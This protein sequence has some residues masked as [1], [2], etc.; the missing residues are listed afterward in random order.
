MKLCY[1][2]HYC[3]VLTHSRLPVAPE[4]AESIHAASRHLTN[5]HFLSP[6]LVKALPVTTST[7]GAIRTAEATSPQV[8]TQP[9]PRSCVMD[10]DC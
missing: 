4:A 3:S 8:A 9:Y 10:K 5:P 2:Y 6:S 1:C 7:S